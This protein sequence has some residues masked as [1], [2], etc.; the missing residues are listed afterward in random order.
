MLNI[1]VRGALCAALAMQCAQAQQVQVFSGGKAVPVADSGNASRPRIPDEHTGRRPLAERPDATAI[2]KAH[3]TSTVRCGLDEKNYPAEQAPSP[4]ELAYFGS[5]TS[6]MPVVNSKDILLIG[7]YLRG[8]AVIEPEPLK[9]HTPQCPAGVGAMYWSV[10]ATRVMFATQPVSAV[11]FHGSRA[12]WSAKFGKV[13]DVWQYRSGAAG[14]R[15]HK[16]ISLPNEKVVDMFVPVEGDSVW[17]LS[18]TEKLDLRHPRTW[19][20]AVSGT[21]ARQ[22]DIILRQVDGSGAVVTTIPVA[23]GVATGFAHFIRE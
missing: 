21:P 16:L 15:F 4:E 13:Q 3:A 18:Q 8:Q 6:Y 19:L 11:N 17:L 9:V 23:S 5:H 1:L 20:K 2:A 14:Q 22:M 10:G 7:Q 12:L